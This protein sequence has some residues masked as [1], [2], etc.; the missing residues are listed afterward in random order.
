MSFF[1]QAMLPF[2]LPFMREAMLIAVLVAIPSALLSCFLVL[3]GWS[4]MGDAISHAIF[5]GVVIA[6]LVGLPLVVGAFAAGMTCAI[7]TGYLS[8]NSRIKQDTI[9]GIVFSGMFG[10][11]LVLYTKI[12]TEVHLDHILFGNILGVL[13]F[14]LW[15]SAAIA[16]LTVAIIAAKWRD[17]LLHAFD[18]QHARAIGLPVRVMHYG[19]LA[20]LSLTIVG[21]L[22]ATGII[23]TIALLIAP[24][25]IAFLVTRRFGAMMLVAVT[26]S[27]A[28]AFLGV[29]A[30]FFIDSAPAP[31]IVLLLAACFVAVFLAT[32]LSGRSRGQVSGASTEPEKLG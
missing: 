31:T 10:F 24:G 21:A 18:P 11:G 13:P 7:A 25:A 17:L 1:D 22:K 4:L 2:T 16:I 12:Q 19:L 23:L 28:C 5:P 29:Y 9:M 32:T 15:Q 3:K 6:Y 8:Q 20:I 27:L 14:D 30:S 26:L